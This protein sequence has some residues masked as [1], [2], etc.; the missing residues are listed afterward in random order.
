M[1]V[2]N[3]VWSVSMQPEMPVPT[4]PATLQ[5]EERKRTQILQNPH[6]AS[7]GNLKGPLLPFVPVLW[8]YIFT[9][10]PQGDLNAHLPGLRHICVPQM[11]DSRDMFLHPICF[12]LAEFPEHHSGSI[13][14]NRKVRKVLLSPLFSF[15][16]WIK[17][18]VYVTNSTGGYSW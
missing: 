2:V 3:D 18:N 11:V 12:L 6:R 15:F 4:L 8:M 17:M 5:A 14:R 9:G 7:E 1:L 10:S 16:F 13:S